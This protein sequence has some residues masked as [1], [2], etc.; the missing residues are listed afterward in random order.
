[1]CFSA[2]F[3]LAAGTVITVVAIDTLRRNESARTLPLAIIPAVFA[4]HTLMSGALWLSF[5]GAI[6]PQAGTAAAWAY[7]LVAFV[8][9]PIL[10]PLSVLLLEPPGW[11]RFALVALTG[12]G[13]V[14]GLGYLI[15]LVG[16]SG[17]AQACGWYIDYWIEA[18]VPF[19]GVLYLIATCWALL[20]S[21]YRPLFLW[22]LTNVLVV[23]VLSDAVPRGLPSLWCLWAAVTS[24]FVNGF[25]RDLN[26]SRAIGEKGPKYGI[27]Q[28]TAPDSR[29]PLVRPPTQPV[30][31]DLTNS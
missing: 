12:A 21:G 31:T 16:G 18:P 26:R 15:G 14:S 1:M 3:D 2:G 6:S 19:S 24:F 30:G 29:A 25:L 20:L 10:I 8:L 5:N 13:V 23:V 28:P 17:S 7:M 22:G 9:L 27:R 11:R 4:A